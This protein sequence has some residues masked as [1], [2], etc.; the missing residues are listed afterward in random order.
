MLNRIRKA[1][2][3]TNGKMQVIAKLKELRGIEYQEKVS[4]MAKNKNKDFNR[5]G[6]NNRNKY[7]SLSCMHALIL[8]VQN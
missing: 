5:V 1:E 7:V 8:T 2:E 3:S 6:N 4:Q